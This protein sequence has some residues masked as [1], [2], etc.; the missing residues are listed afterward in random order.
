MKGVVYSGVD[1]FFLLAE[2]GLKMQ[3]LLRAG[4]EY[5]GTAVKLSGGCASSLRCCSSALS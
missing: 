2:S 4:E 1:S 5:R 3:G